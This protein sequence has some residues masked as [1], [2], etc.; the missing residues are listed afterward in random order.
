MKLSRTIL[1]TVMALA[2]SSANAANHGCAGHDHDHDHNHEKAHGQSSQFVEV[3]DA[4]LK[5]MGLKTVHPQKRRMQSTKVF[6]GRMELA[7]DARKDVPAPV[8]GRLAL[9]VREFDSVKKGD[10]LFTVES[11]TLKS[12]SREIEVLKARLDVYRKLKT[13][14]AEIESALEVKISEKD[15]LVAGAEEKDAVV[16]IRALADAVVEK[17]NVVDGAWVETGTAAATLVDPRALRF[18]AMVVSSD[19][20]KLCDGMEVLVG[21]VHAHLRLGIADNI[22][23]TP[24]YGVFESGTAPGRTGERMLAECALE[25]SETP[26]DALPNECIVK[27]GTDPVVFVR[28]HKNHNRFIVVKVVCG[29]SAGGWTQVSDLPHEDHL[30]VVKEGVY[31][32]KLALA[33]KTSGKKAP[34]HFHA[35]GAFHEGEH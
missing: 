30:D 31:E 26:V 15:A 25:K 33:A 29:I 13:T 3:G 2:V 35:D 8:S 34:G 24:I 14:N 7:S 4:S 20:A 5:S 11:P 1:A 9:K 27:V 21:G 6:W 22:G 23:M 17:L 18:R 16:T 10:V 19:A 32:L 12:L 28:D